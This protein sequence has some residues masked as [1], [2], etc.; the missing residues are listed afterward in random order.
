M[1]RDYQLQLGCSVR[2]IQNVKRKLKPHEYSD[3]RKKA[4]EEINDS[5]D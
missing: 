4:L 5:A 2:H 1:R 3:D